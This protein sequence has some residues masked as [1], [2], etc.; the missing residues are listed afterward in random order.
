MTPP[1]APASTSTPARTNDLGVVTRVNLRRRGTPLVAI[2]LTQA[3]TEFAAADGSSIWGRAGDWKVMNG[4]VVVQILTAKEFPGPYE[5]EQQ[6]TLTLT[7]QDR[8]L[9]EEITGIGST[10]SAGALI[11]ATARLAR[12]AIGDVTIPFTPGQLEEITYRA[13]K[14]GITVQRA[15]QDVI[16]RI[17]DELFHRG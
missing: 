12:I 13:S 3:M 14:R 6:G 2:K 9:L 1:Q 8:E 4:N 16:D 7:K 15:I 10:T 5:I 11:A 17:K